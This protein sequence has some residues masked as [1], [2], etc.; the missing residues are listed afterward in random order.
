MIDTSCRVVDRRRRRCSPVHDATAARHLYGSIPAAGRVR[1]ARGQRRRHRSRPETWDPLQPSMRCRR[2]MRTPSWASPGAFLTANAM[3]TSQ[4]FRPAFARPRPR[5]PRC[6]HRTI[7]ELA[8]G[9]GQ[10]EWP[11]DADPLQAGIRCVSAA[12]EVTTMATSGHGCS[13]WRSERRRRAK[14]SG[15]RREGRPHRRRRFDPHGRRASTRAVAAAAAGAAADMLRLD[16]RDRTGDA[17]RR[18]V[19]GLPGQSASVQAD[20]ARQVA[21]ANLA[22]G[23]KVAATAGEGVRKVSAT[24]SRAARESTSKK[25]ATS[26]EGAGEEDDDQEGR[27]QVLRRR[28]TPPPA[29]RRGHAREAAAAT[30]RATKKA[31]TT[32]KRAAKKVTA[33]TKSTG[34]EGREEGVAGTQR[35]PCQEEGGGEEAGEPA[36]TTSVADD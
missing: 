2:A 30:K 24:A 33:T 35:D 36:S 14:E 7:G 31:A 20:A 32:T 4:R 13:E 23:R 9:I 15:H 26:E 28:R 19:G 29:T 3:R 12:Q 11:G 8:T 16:G 25:K 17:L 21:E 10:R 34:Q 27:G 5:P 6:A 18:S 1:S 22:A